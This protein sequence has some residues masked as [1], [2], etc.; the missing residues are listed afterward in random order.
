VC[1]GVCA[2]AIGKSPR[3]A[4]SASEDFIVPPERLIW[5]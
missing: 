1:E 3:A 5:N 2:R 4:R